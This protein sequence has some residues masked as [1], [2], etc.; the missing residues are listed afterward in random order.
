MGTEC[1]LRA[2][3]IE[4]SLLVSVTNLSPRPPW[5]VLQHNLDVRGNTVS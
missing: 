2:L 5:G 1:T 3:L 4:H